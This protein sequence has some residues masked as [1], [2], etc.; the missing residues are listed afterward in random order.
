MCV[1]HFLPY[2]LWV[3][4]AINITD[5]KI[6]LDLKLHVKTTHAF[7]TTT[8]NFHITFKWKCK[9]YIALR[10]G[11]GNTLDI[12]CRLQIMI[13]HLSNMFVIL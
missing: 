3:M 6:F 1:I 8:S 10:D 5:K 4:I 13:R 2:L 7:A 11:A 9:Y 12:I